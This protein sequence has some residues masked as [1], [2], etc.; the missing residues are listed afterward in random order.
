MILG[1]DWNVSSELIDGWSTPNKYGLLFVSGII[2]GFFVI[3]RMFKQE[4]VQEE[5]LDKL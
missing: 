4:N 3:K 1:I 2:I 5:I